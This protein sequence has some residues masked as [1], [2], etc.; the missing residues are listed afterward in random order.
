MLAILQQSLFVALES[1]RDRLRRPGGLIAALLLV[2]VVIVPNAFTAW[3]LGRAATSADFQSLRLQQ[4]RIVGK[5]YGDEVA[6][7]VQ[8]APSTLGMAAL[9]MLLVIPAAALVM[10][11]GMLDA[12]RRGSLLEFEVS[13]L[14]RAAVV[15]ARAIGLWLAL[16]L[17]A[18][19]ALSLVGI[20]VL[21][22]E[23]RLLF[24]LVAQWTLR[25]TAVCAASALAYVALA[26]FVNVIVPRAGPAL[27]FGAVTL[28]CLLIVRS[29]SGWDRAVVPWFFPGANDAFLLGF[30]VRSAAWAALRTSLWG[31]AVG[32][33]AT[34]VFWRRPA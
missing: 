13:R 30:E 12:N 27:G 7:M 1:G 2:A 11:S 33:A 14:P 18:L 31:L 9:T 28:V 32:T 26:T 16:A 21:V 24:S 29:W 23:P 34:L 19:V 15:A 17:M 22:F 3:M 25:L 20:L 10:A 4:L 8:A 6:E 5:S